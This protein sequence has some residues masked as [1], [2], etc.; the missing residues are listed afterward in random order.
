MNSRTKPSVKLVVNRPTTSKSTISSHLVR[1]MKRLLL[2]P[3]PLE[4]TI[5]PI[6]ASRVSRPSSRR[7]RLLLLPIQSPL[8][9]DQSCNINKHSIANLPSLRARSPVSALTSPNSPT[10]EVG[11]RGVRVFLNLVIQSSELPATGISKNSPTL[12]K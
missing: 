11:S 6:R 2:I 5:R 8:W 7:T 10:D 3:S 12:V 4:R 1:Q 9:V